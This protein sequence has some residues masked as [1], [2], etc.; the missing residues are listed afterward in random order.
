MNLVSINP[1]NGK[2]LK[3]YKA[4]TLNQVG[5]KIKQTHKAWQSWRNTSHDERSKLLLQMAGVLQTRK[6]EFAILMAQ[7]MGKPVGHGVAE[8][9]K[10]ALVCEYYAAHG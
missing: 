7:E 1:A 8:I 5:Q 3:K 4:D 10:C 6:K 2:I 9:E